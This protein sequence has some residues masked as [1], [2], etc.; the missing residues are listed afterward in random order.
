MAA[1][2]PN[3]T[4]KPKRFRLDIVGPIEDQPRLL[5]AYGRACGGEAAL[6]L[7]PTEGRGV[8]VLVS[9]EGSWK[10]EASAETDSPLR[11]S[12]EITAAEAVKLVK[13]YQKKPPAAGP[14]TLRG[15]WSGV[16]ICDE[17][18]PAV[19]LKRKLAT[20]GTLVVR[21]HREQGWSW[22]FERGEKWFS[23]E[24]VTEGQGLPTLSAAIEAG[25]LG[26]MRLVKEA[27]SFRDTR[28]RAAHDPAW[29]ERHPI[30]PPRPT[31]N[32]T[33][34][35][36][37]KAAKGRGRKKKAPPPAAL[38]TP[39]EL[40]DS[41]ATPAALHR[42]A[43]EVEAEGDALAALRGLTWLWVEPT[44]VGDIADFFDKRDLPGMAEAIRAYRAGPDQPQDE[45]LRELGRML[46]DELDEM[47]LPGD[48]PLAKDARAELQELRDALYSTPVQMER[49]R[50]LVQYATRMV[51][52]PLCKGREQRE[53]VEA[54]QRASRAYEDARAAITE[55]RAWDAQRTLRR[56]GERVALGAAKAARACAAGQT[57]LTALAA[58]QGTGQKPK[59]ARRTGKGSGARGS[60]KG[61][62]AKPPASGGD[63][64][65]GSCSLC[66]PE[67]EAAT[68]PP[69]ADAAKDKALLDAF[70]A[71][72]AAALGEEAA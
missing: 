39:A 51:Q 72:I 47:D 67:P 22:R 57:S 19:E 2:N 14:T 31:S 30:K 53:S 62:A 63:G 68:P 24:G 46:T 15:R 29:A 36:E 20:Y 59:P 35:F 54:I 17:G 32:P 56:I 41:P 6:V 23:D 69:E 37:G 50:H 1:T 43:A 71:A 45:F 44:P 48:G 52:S 12:A 49:A 65:N 5:R 8:L 61:T 42:M 55:G 40:P 66:V 26:A 9:K 27:C 16:L 38:D 18:Q 11:P 33:E 28:R 60:R 34:R 7:R 58:E 4:P 25:V 3:P 64:G 10:W 21:S 70:S 13:D